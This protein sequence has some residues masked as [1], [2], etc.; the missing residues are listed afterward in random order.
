MA[1]KP[2]KT[3]DSDQLSR[4]EA[5]LRAT[6]EPVT[7]FGLRSDQDAKLVQRLREGIKARPSRVEAI[8]IYL[9]RR[10]AEIMAAAPKPSK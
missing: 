8:E 10:W 2:K 6:N 9:A 5:F 3:K 1:K 7:M 4:I